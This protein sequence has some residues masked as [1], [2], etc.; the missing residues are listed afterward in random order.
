MWWKNKTSDTPPGKKGGEYSFDNEEYNLHPEK[1]KRIFTNDPTI[2]DRI[3][4]TTA[5]Q[6]RQWMHDEHEARKKAN[7]K[8]WWLFGVIFASSIV[9]IGMGVYNAIQGRL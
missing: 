5:I 1:A 4:V 6:L 3:V 7:R 2:R 9:N 8:W